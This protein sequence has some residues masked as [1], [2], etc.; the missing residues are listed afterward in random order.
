[1]KDFGC[2]GFLDIIIGGINYINYYRKLFNSFL[3]YL[4]IIGIS[5]LV[6]SN[7]FGEMRVYVY[8][9]IYV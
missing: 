9:E 5:S 7:Y 1:M 8:V 6:I 3:S 4:F 2:F